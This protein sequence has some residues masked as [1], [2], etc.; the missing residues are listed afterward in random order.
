MSSPPYPYY[1]HQ[2]KYLALQPQCVYGCFER[3]RARMASDRALPGTIIEI[4]TAHGGLTLVLADLF[5]EARIWTYDMARSTN[6]DALL[7][8][9]NVRQ[10]IRDVFDPAG[11]AEIRR[12]LAQ[13][14]TAMLLCDGGDKVKEFTEF[15]PALKAGDFILAHDADYNH[16]MPPGW[17]WH[18]MSEDWVGDTIRACAL[19]PYLA[20]VMKDAAWLC[21]RRQGFQEPDRHS[22]TDV[23]VP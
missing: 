15:A 2:G 22:K 12:L 8:R 16:Q 4:G 3:L 14:G 11:T 20:E 18:E 1:H 21:K 7:A 23:I 19:R 5:P 17:H 13:P 6:H 10:V 9:A